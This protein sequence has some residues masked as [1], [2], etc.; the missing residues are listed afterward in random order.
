MRES[1]EAFDAARDLEGKPF[2]SLCYA[3]HVQLSFSPN[4]DV[5]ACCMSRSH[6]LDDIWHGERLRQFRD[7]LRRYVFPSG[8]E[9]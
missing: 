2:R 3:P 1:F 7:Q 6:R 4:G 9:S 5:S 8:C